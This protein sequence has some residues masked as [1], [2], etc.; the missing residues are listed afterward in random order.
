MTIITTGQIHIHCSLYVCRVNSTDPNCQQQCDR[1]RKRREISANNNVARLRRDVTNEP[2]VEEVAV[3]SETV[4]FVKKATCR[5]ISC[6]S[7]SHCK[8]MYPA[9]CRCD[10][11]FV[12]NRL[13][14]NCT[15]GHVINVRG[16]HLDKNLPEIY[17]DPDSNV[18]NAFA[19]DFEDRVERVV[20]KDGRNSRKVLGSKVSNDVSCVW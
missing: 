13:T 3:V 4:Y 18:F 2:P 6:P 20:E 7:Y 11:G 16:L 8:E 9:A 14:G 12:K 5:D 10:E 17:A 19:M 15:N 1:L